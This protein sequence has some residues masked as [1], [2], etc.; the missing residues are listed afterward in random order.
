MYK[1]EIS[2]KLLVKPS[3]SIREVIRK[4]TITDYRFQLVVKNNKLLGTIVDGDVR[5]AIL[6]KKSLDDK[7]IS[8]MNK[9]PIVGS[10]NNPSKYE[11]LI[12][13]IGSD[14]KFLP[15]LNKYKNLAYIMLDK[16]KYL[17]IS[18]LIMA[19]GYGRRLGIKTKN[20]PKPMLKIKKKPILEHILQKIQKTE[21]QKI[22][23]ST[24]YLYKKIENYINKRKNKKNIEVLIENKPLGTAGSISLIKKESFDLLVV[25]N[26]DLITDI[27]FKALTTYHLENKNDITITVSKH[28]YNLPYGLVNF[29]EKLSFKS[30]REKP[31]ISNFIL[32]GIYCLNKNICISVKKQKIDMPE[33]INNAH[34]LKK[35]VGIFPIFEYWRDI[36]SPH[37]FE[38]EEGK[39]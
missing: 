6:L 17:N 14:I 20:M 8:C 10:V 26:G 37:D 36:G 28:I 24:F 16:K 5:R 23:L 27:D 9:T 25:I 39:N 12:F 1:I 35:K 19:G 29:D 11:D 3:D 13:S 2:K 32:S 7:V 15:V 4:L 31:D 21:Y 33:I 34:K 18:Y 38:K 30:L 22:Y